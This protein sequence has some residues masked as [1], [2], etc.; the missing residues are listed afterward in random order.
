[1]SLTQVIPLQYRVTPEKKAE[2]EKQIDMMEQA[3]LIEPSVSSWQ[4]PVVPVKKKDSTFHFAVD[5]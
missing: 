2:I 1:M 3:D 4:A 5:Y